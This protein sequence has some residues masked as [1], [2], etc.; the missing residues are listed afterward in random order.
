MN[1]VSVR[2]RLTGL[3]VLLAA[4]L[5]ILISSVG[6][7]AVERDLV[8]TVVAVSAADQL[9]LVEDVLAFADDFRQEYDDLEEFSDEGVPDWATEELVVLLDELVAV[10]ALDE[11]LA[12]TDVDRPVSM[13]VFTYFGDVVRYFPE[14]GVAEWPLEPDEVD[15]P[16]VPQTLIE[17][18]FF[19]SE[20]LRFGDV[21]GV[22][23]DGFVGFVEKEFEFAVVELER[24][25]PEF[26]VLADVS[27]VRASV[28]RIRAILWWA[29]PSAV[30]GAG[31]VAW[32]LAGRALR[33]VH[34]ITS[35]VAE[36]SGGNLHER[37]P[38][39]G[40]GDEV[41]RL[42]STMNAMLDR[43]EIDDAR[44]RRFVSDA[45]HELRSPVA[46][47]RS[48]AE[49]AARAPERSSVSE[50]AEGVLVE[51]ERL[52]RIVEDLLLLARGE[53]RSVAVVV[54]V[55]VDD[56]VLVEAARRRRLPVDTS[57]VS[58]GRVLGSVE[59]VQRTVAHLVDNAVRH[60]SSQVSVGVRTDDRFVVVWVDDDG[61]GVASADRARIFDRFTRLDDAR[62]R[63]RGG[64]GLGL[65]VVAETVG[66]MG[67]TVEV[68]DA[69]AG[70]ARFSL[71]LPAAPH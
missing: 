65:A 40:T 45:S 47:L 21:F 7:G 53:E 36:I 26:V 14:S 25:G 33:P 54:E 64:A 32:F 61:P 27:D 56:V 20:E 43:L 59:A 68:E 49:V 66:R 35:R 41:A 55:D 71:R 18:L 19:L 8:D 69:T 23:P 38:Q 63:D 52:Q 48:E 16:L 67:G 17:E 22:R 34:A 3:V 28:A 5:G 44:L 46:V 6:V 15:G 50:L 24:D 10:G 1:R 39:P 42:A 9:G 58:A 4:I 60:A 13:D 57:Q 70:G 30:I 37:V 51:A 29:V 62:T 31:L 11:V 12:A 2:A